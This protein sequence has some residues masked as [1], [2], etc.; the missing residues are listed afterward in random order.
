[1]HGDLWKVDVHSFKWNYEPLSLLSILDE[2]KKRYGHTLTAS[3]N[4]LYVFGG[5]THTRNSADN[6][7]CP[8]L[9]RYDIE[10]KTWKILKANGFSC[11]PRRSHAAD[12]I[13]RNLVIVGGI[14][15]REQYLSDFVA[16]NTSNSPT[17]LILTQS[18]IGAV[19]L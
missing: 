16:F 11:A 3:R 4:A 5:V 2:P 17:F 10:S 8:E 12:F 15:S 13:G 18:R 1:M 7:L 9:H 19:L 14:G 6:L